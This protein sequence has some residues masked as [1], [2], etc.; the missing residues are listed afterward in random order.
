MLGAVRTHTHTHMRVGEKKH[1]NNH[2]V[3][4]LLFSVLSCWSFIN[5]NEYESP[6]RL[7][8]SPRVWQACA[9]CSCV[10]LRGRLFGKSELNS[11][12]LHSDPNTT[13]RVC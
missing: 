2:S 13:C 5:C 4:L 10:L 11:R 9:R 7:L 1:R 12:K 8:N 6:H 3:F